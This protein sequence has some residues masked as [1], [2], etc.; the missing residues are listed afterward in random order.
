[1]V[2]GQHSEKKAGRKEDVDTTRI[3]EPV[4]IYVEQAESESDSPLY[5]LF[6]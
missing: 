2:A 5:A 3:N 4:P 6:I 1:V